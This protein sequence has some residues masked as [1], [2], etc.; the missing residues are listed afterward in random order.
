MLYLCRLI[1]KKLKTIF[2]TCGVRSGAALLTRMLSVSDDFKASS[3][4]LNFFRFFYN[5]YDSLDD[6]KNLNKAINDAHIR[7]KSRFNIIL[8]KKEIINFFKVNNKNYKNLYKIFCHQIFKNQKYRYVGD[9][10]GN[11]WRHIP[12]YFKMFPSGKA[13]LII[14]D[15]RD[16]ICSFKKFTISKKN[17]YLISLFNFVDLVNYY[18]ILKKK[19]KKKIY[20]VKFS[21]I[22]QKPMITIKKICKFLVIDYDKNMLNSE[23]FKDVRGEKWNS[24][25]AFTFKGSLKLKTL[26]RWKLLMSDEDLFLCELIAKIQMKLMGYVLSGK[27][28]KKTT[29]SKALQKIYG[30]EILYSS[31]KNWERTGEGNPMYPT[32]PTVPTNWDNR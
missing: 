7:L 15:P 10:Q 19:F 3:A 30:S 32:D 11:A 26:D 14:R 25:K 23:Y 12:D 16:I 1:M 31:Y 27:I 2:L 6:K 21:D 17:D 8:D 24:N 22:K 4:I 5:K 29:K 9:K 28:I 18:S 13:I 20:L